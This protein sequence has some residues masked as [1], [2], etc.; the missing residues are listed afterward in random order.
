MFKTILFLYSLSFLFINCN[1][2]KMTN[3]STNFL[4]SEIIFASQEAATN[5][6]GTSDAFT[7]SMSPFDFAAKTQNTEKNKEKDYLDYAAQQA[8]SW[9]ETDITDTETV[10]KTAAEKIESMGL[11][12]DL[13]ETITLVLSSCLEEGA[14]EGYTREN[15]IVFK[16]KPSIELFLHELWHIISRANPDLRDQAYKIIGFEKMAKLE[17]PEELNNLRITNPDAP[18]MEHYITLS[19]DEVEKNLVLCTMASAPYT[20]GSFFEYLMIIMYEVD[21]SGDTPKLISSPPYN[22]AN[23]QGFREKVGN[24]TNYII[25]PEEITA[26]HFTHLIMEKEVENPEIINAL[27]DLLEK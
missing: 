1:A 6:L 5:L 8:K 4:E 26:E 23:V 22:I 17:F 10:L 19:V 27:K 14:A 20:E 9:T 13:P 15:Y 12:I 21:L 25:H 16:S 7:K 11:K 3:S 2:E 24:N 18:F